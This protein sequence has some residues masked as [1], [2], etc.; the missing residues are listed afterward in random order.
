MARTFEIAI[1][2]REG[3]QGELTA[4][5]NPAAVRRDDQTMLDSPTSP[6][7]GASI[8]VDT[9]NPIA[10]DWDVPI[11]AVQGGQVELYARFNQDILLP[12]GRGLEEDPAAWLRVQG[13]DVDESTFVIEVVDDE[14]EFALRL[15]ELPE[16]IANDTQFSFIVST[17]LDE[18]LS[19]A[20][21]ASAVSVSA[22]STPTI[23]T[24]VPLEAYQF[25]TTTP[26][27]GNGTITITAN[28]SGWSTITSNQVLGSVAYGE[29]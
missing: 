11:G 28:A 29:E 14:D 27:T 16:R 22:G 4:R 23:C 25:T 18:K 5:I 8:E 20:P 24:A 3:S 21:T 2:P 13:I 26:A 12:D 19:A 15:S 10:V 17:V 6:V 1:T 9:S 7:T